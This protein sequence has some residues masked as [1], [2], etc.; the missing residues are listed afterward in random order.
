MVFLSGLVQLKGSRL[1]RAKDPNSLF[2]CYMFLPRF[3]HALMNCSVCV[4]VSVREIPSAVTA[5]EV[6]NHVIRLWSYQY[7]IL[8]C[9]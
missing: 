8:Q 4:C 5:F 2:S 3:D 7:R 9:H 1:E 6:A